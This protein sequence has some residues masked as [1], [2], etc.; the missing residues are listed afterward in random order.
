MAMMGFAPKL[1]MAAN[2][3]AFIA[4]RTA[5]AAILVVAPFSDVAPARAEAPPSLERSPEDSAKIA[6]RLDS[7][8]EKLPAADARD[9]KSI[10]QEISAIL[11]SHGSPTLDLILERGRA[12][13]SEGDAETAIAHFSRLVDLAPD[14]TEAWNMRATAYYL[15]DRLGE[16][17][18]D[19][20]RV[21]ALEPRHFGALWGL[22]LILERI[23]SDAKALKAF[24]AAVALNPHLTDADE[25]IRRLTAK[26]EGFEI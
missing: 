4:R 18:A 20:A 10:Q 2:V 8:F 19:I 22:G 6:G 24:R 25:T 7:L 21:L 26:V 15:E 12:A 1:H 9:A 16:S 5:V 3:A 13:L 14:F 17:A 11:S 23:G